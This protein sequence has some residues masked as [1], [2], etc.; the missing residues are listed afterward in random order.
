MNELIG[1]QNMLR[2]YKKLILNVRV[3]AADFSSKFGIRRGVDYTIYD[4]LTAKEKNYQDF[5]NQFNGIIIND[6]NIFEK[7]EL[8]RIFSPCLYVFSIYF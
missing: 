1:I 4:I 5:M 8:G 6:S 2:P 3:G 7:A